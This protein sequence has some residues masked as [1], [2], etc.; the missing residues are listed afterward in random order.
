[1][2]ATD[3]R[4]F[5][6]TLGLVSLVLALLVSCSGTNGDGHSDAD[7]FSQIVLN[8]RPPETRALEFLSVE[9]GVTISRQLD[10]IARLQIDVLIPETQDRITAHINIPQSDVVVVELQIPQGMNRRIDVRAFNQVD[11][12]LYEGT[13]QVDLMSDTQDVGIELRAVLS[14]N[15]LV[16]A[17]IDAAVGAVLTANDPSGELSGLMVTIPPDAFD[18]NT[19]FTLGTRNNASFLPPL[20]PDVSPTGPVLGFNAMGERL[21]EPASITIPYET[22]D[23][24]VINQFKTGA[25]TRQLVLSDQDLMNS[26]FYF[27]VLRPGSNTWQAYGSALVNADDR[28][29]TVPF[30]D[31]GSGVIG[32][33]ENGAL[34]ASAPPLIVPEDA[35]GMRQITI[36]NPDPNQAYT[37]SIAQLPTLGT[38]T[39]QANGVVTYT[40]A[41]NIYGADFLSIAVMASGDPSQSITVDLPIT[42]TPVNDPPMAQPSSLMTQEEMPF[43]GTLM[44][45]DVDGDTLSFHLA[46][47]AAKGL[48]TLINPTMGT[49]TYTPHMNMYGP[50]QFSF[51]VSDGQVDSMHVTV[52]IMIAPVNDLPVANPVMLG[53]PEDVAV[54]GMLPAFDPDGD[55]LTFH[56]VSQGTKGMAVIPN[57]NIGA[58]IYT[59]NPNATGPD[60]FTFRVN[61]GTGNSNPAPVSLTIN[62][63]NDIPVATPGNFVTNEDMNLV[64]Q[65]MAH[66]ADVDPLTFSVVSQGTLGTVVITNPNTGAFTYTPNP[67]ANGGDTFTFRVNDG[68]V[69][70][71]LAPVNVMITP[72]N[73]PPVAFNRTLYTAGPLPTSGTL[74]GMDVDGDALTFSIETPPGNGGIAIITD[75]FTGTYTYDPGLSPPFPPNSFTYRVNDG[76]TNSNIATVFID[77][78]LMPFDLIYT[79]QTRSIQHAEG[80]DVTALNDGSIVVSGVFEGTLTLGAGTATETQLISSGQRDLFIARYFADGSLVWARQAGGPGDD[81]A[82]GVISLLDDSVVVTG[83]FQLT[84]TFGAGEPNEAMLTSAGLGDIFVAKFDPAGMLVWASRAGGSGDE[85]SYDIAPIIG[86]I[87]ESVITGSFQNTATFDGGQPS[88]VMLTSAGL[89]DIFIAQYDNLGRLTWAT[90]AGGSGDDEGTAID[91]FPSIGIALTGVFRTTATFGA[92]EPGETM[93]TSAGL[94]DIFIA[95]YDPTGLLFAVYQ[96]GGSGEDVGSGISALGTGETVITGVFENTATFMDGELTNINLVAAGASDIF[97]VKYDFDFLLSWAVRAGGNGQDKPRDIV[98]FPDDTMAITGAFEMAATFGPAEPNQTVLTSQGLA[99]MFVAHYDPSGQLLIAKRNGSIGDD[100]ARG[101]AMLPGGDPVITGC[102]EG[103][104]TFGQGQPL[105]ATLTSEGGKDGFVTRVFWEELPR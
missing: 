44:A 88:E 2:T 67:N 27:F 33:V 53:T 30:M 13:T 56:I 43:T 55:A 29:L 89:R 49:Y 70:S 10:A 73:D 97:L 45:S 57:P 98:G 7:G 21:R 69:N 96:A 72:V 105:E 46:Q 1:M 34:I 28:T 51:Y 85:K 79:A 26:T 36:Q 20:P 81:E 74:L 50:D 24:T 9:N 38:A 102:F 63:M 11:S 62:A 4:R 87:E 101:M 42:V 59:P 60:V 32:R 41:P 54:N 58:F 25:S 37:F 18:Q 77:Q 15:T 8:I 48:V 100:G 80:T 6:W 23:A 52:N 103:M 19:V 65:L 22:A 64:G 71:N 83:H 84:A 91:T 90:R 35:V 86:S 104:V 93:L 3:C 5:M 82:T 75:M 76:T 40:P 99:D 14:L 78:P 39:V 68:V 61:D 17:D 94:G 31:F 66:D 47:P 92:S 12:L 95:H 16:Q